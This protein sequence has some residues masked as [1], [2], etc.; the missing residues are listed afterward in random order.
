MFKK[1]LHSFWGETLQIIILSFIIVIPF[2]LYIAQPFLVSGPSMDDTFKNNQY[3]IV[4]ELTY[5][6]RD[7][8][9]G[10]VI[11]F[12]YPL[13]TKKYFIKRVIGLPGET[14]EIKQNE[15][16]IWQNE[17]QTEEDRFI[18]EEP[19]IKSQINKVSSP[20]R[21]DITYT[22]KENEYYVLGDNRDVSSDS[23]FWGPVKRELIT[24]RPFVRLLP[25]NKISILPGQINNI[26]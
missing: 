3:L 23:R 11:I 22:L 4:D 19:Y 5:H 2:R 12:K 17:Y 1:F 6:L 18:L 13:D 8:K 24:G 15:I 14:I 26:E 20:S 9:R 25:L 16:T 7:P 10:E 21:P